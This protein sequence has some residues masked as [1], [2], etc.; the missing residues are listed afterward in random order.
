MV[1]E[2]K[3]L[4]VL[5]I[6]DNE[7]ALRVMTMALKTIEIDDVTT[8]DNAT[9]AL[10]HLDNH[11]ADAV[12]C[13]LNMPGM[14]GMAFLGHLSSRQFSGG[15][16]VV[17]GED[18][19]G[20]QAAAKWAG[21]NRLRVLG[22]FEKPVTAA[23]LSVALDAGAAAASSDKR[24]SDDLA[25]ID[26]DRLAEQLGS[27]DKSR[28]SET[29]AL[30]LEALP[31]LLSDVEDAVRA[32]DAR[33]LHDLAHKAKGAANTAAAAPLAQRLGDLENDAVSENWRDFEARLG[34]IQLEYTR[35]DAFC[36]KQGIHSPSGQG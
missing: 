34:K 21:E 5:V 1:H 2:A 24:Q 8:M 13:D 17:S 26:I 28:I 4:K 16:V 29:L 35:I 14:D 32:R 20:L 36:T 7:F 25:A 31:G 27:N 3:R 19:A 30:F 10:A 23:D 9:Q 11:H 18:P 12:I 22:T 33:S 15:I 6:D